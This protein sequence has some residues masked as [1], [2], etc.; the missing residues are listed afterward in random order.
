MNN[1]T[2][3]HQNDH[4]FLNQYNEAANDHSYSYEENHETEMKEFDCPV[5]KRVTKGNKK[6]QVTESTSEGPPCSSSSEKEPPPRKERKRTVS[7][8][9]AFSKLRG[10]IPNVPTDTKLSKI[11]TLRLA[12]AYIQYLW[13]KLDDPPDEF[14]SADSATTDAKTSSFSLEGF[15]VDLSRCKRSRNNSSLAPL[16]LSSTNNTTSAASTENMTVCNRRSRRSNKEEFTDLSHVQITGYRLG[17][18][19]DSQTNC[20]RKQHFGCKV[21]EGEESENRKC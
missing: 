1:L 5:V 14:A 18:V 16:L 21:S 2:E 12:T 20:I 13:K 3:Y 7:I 8:N 10:R 4:I 17:A 9:T 6:R 19:S 11:K 15:K